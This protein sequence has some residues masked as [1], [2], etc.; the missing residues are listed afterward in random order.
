M[1][2]KTL[3]QQLKE[4]SAYIESKISIRPEIAIVLGSGLG[5]LANQITDP[6]RIPYREIP[7]FP[8]STVAGHAGQLIIGKLGTRSVM[9]M[10]GRFH[11]YEGYSMDRLVFPIQVM[12]VMGIEKLI[13]TNASGCVN[14]S[15]NSGDLML[16]TDHIKLCADSPMR[17]PN[18]PELGERFFDMC[19]VYEPAYRQIAKEEAARLGITLREGVYQYFTGPNYETPAEVRF[20]RIAGADAVGMSTVPEAIAARHCGLK[21][22]GIS[23]MTNMAAGVTSAPLN[24]KEV[25]ET[26]LKIAKQFESLIK[27]II[28]RL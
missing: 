26:S 7:H 10:A 12:R 14:K 27:S 25:L 11:Y 2:D 13:L 28:E 17:G 22:L 21:V 6:V 16:I 18:D 3:M 4:A 1:E 20:A 5:D 19:N 8:V 24:H 15:W 23:C 9:C